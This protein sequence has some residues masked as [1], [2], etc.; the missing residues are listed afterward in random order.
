MSYDPSLDAGEEA[1]AH[2]RAALAAMD[3]PQHVRALF[4]SILALALREVDPSRRLGLGAAFVNDA[5][6]FLAKEAA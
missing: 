5:L 3:D 2:V 1:V 4:A 6:L